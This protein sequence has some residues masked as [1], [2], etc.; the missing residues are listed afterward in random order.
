M[1]HPPR[2]DNIRALPWPLYTFAF[3]ASAVHENAYPVE[4]GICRW[5]RPG[6]SLERWSSLIR[7]PDY[8]L[9]HGFWSEASS[10]I[11]GIRFADLKGG[12]TPSQIVEVLNQFASDL[13]LYSDGGTFQSDFDC[14]RKVVDVSAIDP[15]FSLGDWV[16]MTAR[17]SF[18]SFKLASEWLEASPTPTRAGPAAERLMRSLV[19]GLR[20]D[21]GTAVPI[22]F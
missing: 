17:S 22:K 15:A 19:H 21:R 6:A 1:T 5:S 16:D 8:W 3:E 14:A 4:I 20:M 7:P 13:V 12:K 18:Y 2:L 11:S 10:C 9:D